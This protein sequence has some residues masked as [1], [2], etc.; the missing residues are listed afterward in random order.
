MPWN[1]QKGGGGPWGGSGNGGSGGRGGDG[2]SPWGRP[3]GGGG[4]GQSPDLE[5]S[6]KR[7]QERWRGRRGGGSGSG[8]R[9]GRGIGGAGF[10]V[11][12][13]AALVGWLLTGVF[14]VNEQEQ[15]VVLQFGKFHS[16]RQPGFHVRLPDPIQS[17]QIVPVNVIQ[18][19]EIGN[20]LSESQMLTGDENIVDIDYTVFWKVNSPQEFLFNVKDPAATLRT[21][22]ESAMREV[23]GKGELQPIITTGRDEVQAATRELIQTTLDS[24]GA[25][26]LV[27]E[28][29]I[30]NSDPPEPVQEA[31]R[32][33]VNAAQ[34]K[35][36]TINQATAY[37]NDVV[38]RARG[39][40][41]RII[42]EAE[43][44][45]ESTVAQANG[46]AARFRSIYDEYRKAPRVTRER[47]FLETM[48]SVLGKS[49]QIILDSDAG[50]VPYL[51]LDQVRRG[52]NQ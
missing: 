40:A 23:V 15:A 30:A 44:Y 49:E 17:H 18:R 21:V 13:V 38:P 24:Y 19:V 35:Q 20:S 48:E 50:A 8:G 32:D 37:A 2:D 5:D 16:T 26:I 14:T 28:V 43:A 9:R 1:D 47:M 3:S 6:L 27:T 7:M 10:A 52:A 12:F 31:F 29:N 11:L 41:Q 46:E 33:V 22:A 39:D 4:G 25:G 51:P 42:Q 45:R 36:T 34:D